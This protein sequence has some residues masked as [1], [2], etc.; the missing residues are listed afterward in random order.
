VPPPLVIAVWWSGGL[1]RQ[2]VF[3]Q[4][5]SS[6]PSS[7]APSEDGFTV[8][9]VTD[10]VVVVAGDLANGIG[11]GGVKALAARDLA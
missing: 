6:R 9:T 2:V 8:Q 10:I 1:V 7:V 5:P 11:F 3:T 4:P